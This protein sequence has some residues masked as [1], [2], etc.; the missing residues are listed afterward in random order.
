[1][2]HLIR[3]AG[4]VKNQKHKHVGRKILK[5]RSSA[6]W[7]LSSGFE[8]CVVRAAYHTQ[9]SV[10]SLSLT[11]SQMQDHPQLH[12][13]HH[14]V[15]CNLGLFILCS[16]LPASAS[17]FILGNWRGLEKSGLRSTVIPSNCP[18]RLHSRDLAVHTSR[19]DLSS[20]VIPMHSCQMCQMGIPLQVWFSFHAF[21]MCK[22]IA[23][24]HVGA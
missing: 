2:E 8:T 20:R 21:P 17:N 15:S 11:N 12:G 18:C 1:M 3:D 22:S 13:N 24:K 7:L 14:N 6:A 19:L 23:I 16:T 10:Y 9:L 5:D 4:V